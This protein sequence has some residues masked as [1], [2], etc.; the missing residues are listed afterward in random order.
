MPRGLHQ[1]V[2]SVELPG[3]PDNDLAGAS[4]PSRGH[5]YLSI[6][7]KR[8]KSLPPFRQ[9]TLNNCSDSFPPAGRW[10]SVFGWGRQLVSLWACG[11]A[12]LV[13][14]DTSSPC[15]LGNRCHDFVRPW[16]RPYRW[17]YSS[18]HQRVVWILIQLM[19]DP[20]TEGDA[21]WRVIFAQQLIYD[22]LFRGVRCEHFTVVQRYQDT[23]FL[24]S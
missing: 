15:P 18:C 23:V 24:F 5:A 20:S 17:H 4:P 12:F 8:E 6:S 13:V 19:V 9:M 1:E 11:L 22:M 14:S 16:T 3:F 21:P 7:C 10:G 2:R